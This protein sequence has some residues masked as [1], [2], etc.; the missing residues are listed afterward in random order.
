MPD[1]SRSRSQTKRDTL[2]LR[3]GSW[4]CGSQPHTVKTKLPRNQIISLGWMD[5]EDRKTQVEMVRGYT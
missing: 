1:R 3:I 2:V 5:N 4:A